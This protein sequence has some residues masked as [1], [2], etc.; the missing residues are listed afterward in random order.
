M[1]QL[2]EFSRESAKR[3]L[4]NI[5]FVDDEIYT[6]ATD[7]PVI[8]TAELPAFQSPFAAQ[9]SADDAVQK[10]SSAQPKSFISAVASP[11]SANGNRDATLPERTT[12]L[13]PIVAS[14]P[15][16]EEKTPYHP[17]QLVES[18]AREGMICALYEPKEGFA[19]DKDSELYKLCERA[20]LS[21]WIGICSVWMGEIFCR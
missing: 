7:Q 13:V 6:K 19:A 9:Q 1:T 4:Q 2:A 20:M 21:C 8:S 17:R 15:A 3:Y 10:N 14:L 5:V 18:F 12:Q 11:S 16:V